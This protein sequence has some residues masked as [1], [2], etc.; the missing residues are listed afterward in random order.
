PRGVDAQS[1]C[2][3]RDKERQSDRGRRDGL[4]HRG[5]KLHGSSLFL[6]S[7]G[8]EFLIVPTPS[9]SQVLFTLIVRQAS[10]KRSQRSC[11][12][13]AQRRLA[14]LLVGRRRPQQFKSKGLKQAC[15]SFPWRR[16]RKSTRLNS[17]HQIISYAL[18]CSK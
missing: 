1:V 2:V 14:K 12:I 13:A 17:S 8:R 6:Y 11:C 15:S 9:P 10:P 3:E 7:V 16:D 4:R 5:P 18:F